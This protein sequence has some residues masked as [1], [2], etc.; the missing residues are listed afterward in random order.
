MGGTSMAAP[1][2]GGGGAFYLSTHPDASSTSVEAA[3]TSSA[4]QS[5]TLSKDGRPILLENVQAS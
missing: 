2:V 1:H 5:G 3:L 4:L